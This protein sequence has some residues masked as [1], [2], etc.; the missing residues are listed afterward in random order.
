M[1]ENRRTERFLLTCSDYSGRAGAKTAHNN[2]GRQTAC[3]RLWSKLFKRLWI[4]NSISGT[5]DLMK[6]VKLCVWRPRLYLTHQLEMTTCFNATS[7]L[8]QPSSFNNTN[9]T[10]TKGLYAAWHEP[11]SLELYITVFSSCY[12]FSQMTPSPSSI[13]ACVKDN[14][15]SKLWLKDWHKTTGRQYLSVG[16]DSPRPS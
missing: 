5:V 10:W 3:T 15:P 4:N 7:T 11:E 2:G 8:R 14:C 6:K 12:L 9:I 16:V 13:L 1:T